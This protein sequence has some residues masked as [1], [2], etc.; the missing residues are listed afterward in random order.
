TAIQPLWAAQPPWSTLDVAPV[1]VA[2]WMPEAK[3]PTMPRAS[4]TCD[5]ERPL[6]LARATTVPNVPS[7]ALEWYPRAR[8]P[9]PA[10][11]PSRI[12]TSYPT[13]TAVVTV[14]RS[15]PTTSAAARTAGTT[16][17]PGR[18][19]EAPCLSSISNAW[20]KAPFTSAAVW[21][22]V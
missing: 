12:I 3:V 6:V 15:A 7:R 9:D 14:A 20:A 21:T 16:D 8:Q 18:A 11:K 17:D 10:A 22:S 19:K 4:L 5:R 2:S 1:L 13:A